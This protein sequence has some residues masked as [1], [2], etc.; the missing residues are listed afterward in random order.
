[1]ITVTKIEKRVFQGVQSPVNPGVTFNVG[2]DQPVEW[3]VRLSPQ[4]RGFLNIFSTD[5]WDKFTVYAAHHCFDGHE[6]LLEGISITRLGLVRIASINRPPIEL[7]GLCPMTWK[8][9]YDSR[10]AL[11]REPENLFDGLDMSVVFDR[12]EYNSLY[13]GPGVML[14]LQRII[15]HG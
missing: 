12:Y 7:D 2:I 1:M 11:N 9:D 6:D 14:G 5:P 15:A 8:A 13:R 10:E 4:E 3:A